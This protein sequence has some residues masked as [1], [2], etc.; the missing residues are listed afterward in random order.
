MASVRACSPIS[1]RRAGS[2]R[3]AE[4]LLEQPA[5]ES[6]VG[7]ARA[8]AGPVHEPGIGGLL[9]AAGAGQRDVER[10]HAELAALVHGAS[11]A[12]RRSTSAA[13]A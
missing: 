12:A 1:L 8:A 5:G 4:H 2:D 10:R 6:S 3:A 11:A 7:E 13:A 9:V